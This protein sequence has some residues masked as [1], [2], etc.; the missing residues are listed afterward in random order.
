[1][2]ALSLRSGRRKHTP[3]KAL[4]QAASILI[5]HLDLFIADEEYIEGATEDASAAIEVGGD[6]S[7]NP[8]LFKTLMNLSSRSARIIA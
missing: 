2:I 4:S 3:Q 8:N 7:S 1:L 6:A 5:E